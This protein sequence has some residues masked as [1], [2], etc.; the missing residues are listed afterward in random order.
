M[1]IYKTILFPFLLFILI[2]SC[3]QG[4]SQLDNKTKKSDVKANYWSFVQN[5]TKFEDSILV[6]LKTTV[7]KYDKKIN[8]L[9]GKQSWKGEKNKKTRNT[10]NRS[11]N[12]EIIKKI[13]KDNQK[14]YQLAH[15]NWLAIKK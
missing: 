3:D 4:N 6:N 5:Q 12:K 14:K 2:V 13:G 15:K 9:K 7:S 1:I 10:L 11:K 8:K